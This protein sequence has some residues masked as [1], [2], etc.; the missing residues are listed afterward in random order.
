MQECMSLLDSMSD[1]AVVTQMPRVMHR[2]SSLADVSGPS[3]KSF[4]FASA[5]QVYS[6]RNFTG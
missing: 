2:I 1:V 6:L 3:C 5:F 4:I